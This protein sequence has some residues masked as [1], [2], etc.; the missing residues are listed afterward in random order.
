MQLG[1]DIGTSAVKVALCDGA[2][3]LRSAETPLT[4]QSPQL[5]WSEQNPQDWWTATV[6][7]LH[8]LGD[9][10]DVTAIGLSG[11]MHGAVLLD[12][13]HSVLRPAIL[14]NDNRSVAECHRLSE[15][16]PDIGMRAGVPPLPGFTAP[17]LMWLKAHEPETYSRLRHILL[18]KDYIGLCLHGGLATDMS[19]AAGTLWLDQASRA[20]SPDL[21]AASDTEIDWLPTLHYGNERCGD[22]SA[23][24]A[25]ETGLRAGTP[26]YA[27]GGDAATGAISL[28]ITEPDRGMIS[29]GTSGQILLA[30]QQYR[31][32]PQAYVHAFA[33]TVPDRWYQM[34]ALL[35]GARPLSWLANLLGISVAE[36]LQSAQAAD[37]NRAPIFLPYL[38]GE[39]S[40]LG[41]PDVRGGFAFLDDATSRNELAYSV[42]EAITF[43]FENAM[44]SFGDTL[45]T[46]AH[47]IAIGGGS[48]SD[49]LLQKIADLTGQDIHRPK[50]AA[51][52]AAVGAALLA[53]SGNANQPLDQAPQDCETF[54]PNPNEAFENRRAAFQEFYGQVGRGRLVL[55]P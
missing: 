14:W 20:W 27:G 7:A 46:T 4:V 37:P 10:S 16:C 34:A 21:C 25:A 29:L 51:A 22:V 33:H 8:Q 31:P 1:I 32:N 3:V 13:T 38:T 15:A 30:G 41:D 26:I 39:R 12:Q 19:D 35:N 44:Q 48:R 52:G 24:A 6:S 54:S 55:R 23:S 40:P 47:F 2:S 42:V 5:G 49:F 53:G 28:G 18:P 45:D 9:L 36:L 50:Y 43:S 17:K 11:Q